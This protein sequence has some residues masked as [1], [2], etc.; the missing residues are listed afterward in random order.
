[1]TC[2]FNDAVYACRIYKTYVGSGSTEYHGELCNC[3][4]WE[5]KPADLAFKAKMKAFYDN[6]ALNDYSKFRPRR[7]RKV[8]VD[9]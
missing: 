7:R 4:W 6:A 5:D 3:L 2:K 1:M 9:Y 8:E